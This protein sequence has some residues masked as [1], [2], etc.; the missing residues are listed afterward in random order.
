MLAAET[1]AG[2]DHPI[3]LHE[4]IPEL[5]EKEI[6]DLVVLI[7]TGSERYVTASIYIVP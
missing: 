5:K 3:H 7:G 1:I 6:R 4:V 2:S